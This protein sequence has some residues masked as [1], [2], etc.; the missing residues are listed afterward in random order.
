ME[1]LVFSF[2]LPDDPGFIFHHT[3]GK[4]IRGKRAKDANIFAIKQCSDNT[5]CPV[6]NLK[7]SVQLSDLMKIDLRD[8]YLSRVS[9]RKGNISNSP[10]IGSTIANRLHAHLTALNID[11]GETMHSFSSGCSITLSL[12]G[13]SDQQVANHVG[14]R[15]LETARYYMQ[16][17]KVMQL[18]QPASLL[19]EG[20]TSGPDGR[21]SAA[22][23]G[24][25]FRDRND[26]KDFKLAF[27]Q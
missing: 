18:S 4:T 27:W 8:G 21:N 16:A 10:F 17:D 6:S 20:T 1:R 9:D 3:F 24:R 12:L 26:L 11:D 15:S 23:L 25:Q 7:L 14:W 2:S 22:N 19:A 5:V 13:A